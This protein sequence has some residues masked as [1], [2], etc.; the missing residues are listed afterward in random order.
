MYSDSLTRDNA[1]KIARTKAT[2]WKRRNPQR[3]FS[4]GFESENH[5]AFDQEDFHGTVAVYLKEPWLRH[6]VLDWIMLDMMISRE[7]SAFGEVLKQRWLPGPRNTY[8]AQPSAAVLLPRSN[9][10]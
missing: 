3:S 4:E 9:T 2:I 6:P 5:T 7:L 10:D 1:A 8:G